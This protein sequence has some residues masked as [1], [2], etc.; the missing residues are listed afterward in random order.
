MAA[1]NETPDADRPR[2]MR[3]GWIILTAMAVVIILPIAGFA[4]L[5]ARFNPASLVAPVTAA[6]ERATGRTLMISGPVSIKLSLHPVIEAD[7][8]TLSNPAGYATADLLSLRQVQAR[9]GLLPLFSHHIDI[10]ELV[11]VAPTLNLSRNA[12]GTADWDV[13]Q[14]PPAPA[15][16]APPAPATNQTGYSIALQAV[17]ITDGLVTMPG[18]AISLPSLTGTA[19]SFAAPLHITANALL[20][21]A[22]VTL[23]GSVGPIARFSGTGSGPWP[24]DLTL[25]LGG[26][27]AH[28][29]GSVASPRTGQGYDAAIS[30]L[31]PD[32]TTLTAALPQSLRGTIALPPVKNITGSVHITDQGSLMPGLSNLSIK[33]GTSD[34]SAF[35]PGLSLTT[36]DLE[37]PALS[38]PL[39]ITA[40]GAQGA[41]PLKLSGSLGPLQS[42]LP[43][44]W[45]PA[46]AAPPGS[47]PVS[48]TATAGS[49]SLSLTGA[50]AT[51]QKLAGVALALSA[52]IP[53]LSALSPLSPAPLPAWKNISLQTTLVDPGGLGLSQ[54]IGLD[55]LAL[56]MDNAA[57]GGDASLYF[58]P[59]PR[60]QAA[61]KFGTLN[62]DALLPAPAPAAQPGGTAMPASPAPP[63]WPSWSLPIGLLKTSSADIQLA[64][65]SLIWRHAT[66]AALAAHAVLANG[67]LTINPVTGEVPGGGVTASASIDATK[68]PAAET[69]Q[70]TGPALALAP[71]LNA[72]GLPDTAQGTMQARLAATATG[73][74]L[75]TMAASLSG[76]L[77]IALV[78]GVVDGS[79]MHA[80][81]G[82]M[83]Q[84]I[85]LPD[86]LVSAQGPVPVRCMALA[87]NAAN[88]TGTVRTL[89]LDSSRLLLQGGGSLNFGNQ[90][91]NLIL[92]PEF[93]LAGSQLS[94]PVR[95]A[96]PFTNPATGLAPVSAVAD[97]AKSAVGLPVGIVNK[98][99]GANNLIGKAAG[100]LGI[101]PNADA[102]PAALALGRLGNPGPAAPP[103]SSTNTSGAAPATSGP[104]NLLKALFGT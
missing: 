6:V 61:L 39:S 37:M 1:L 97:A 64:A 51:P 90:T 49:A 104:A 5:V 77:G 80:L 65:D 2:R 36:L 50:I 12:A 18:A 99:L 54:S 93:P 75:A 21:A 32:L 41:I 70:I 95:V 19:E 86:S 10:S 57:L 45:F 22:P 46:G 35:A 102:C 55:D 68:S 98:L 72:F 9:I 84:A 73:D 15:N 16:A 91:M 59:Q 67:V 4:L 11:L 42:V 47:Y 38:A 52:T 96:G 3:R 85:G 44:A 63:A 62:L 87:V 24:V 78:N 34:L 79:V 53:D 27:T 69:L 89:T 20:G 76:Q 82:A 60:L 94:L 33:T 48:L 30:V 74:T 88:G 7:G 92:V 66:Y 13:S 71:F 100:A 31:I 40:T 56:T 83:V 8:L 26:A 29:Q 101:G 103:M 43:A 28:V 25:G 81:F 58:G 17:K 14:R 23:T